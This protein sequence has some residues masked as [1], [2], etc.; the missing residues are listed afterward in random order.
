MSQSLDQFSDYYL[1]EN[2]TTDWGKGL[3]FDGPESAEVRR[4]VLANAAYW[5]EEF[6]FDGLR[7]DATQDIHDTSE[8]HILAALARQVRTSAGGRGTLVVAENEPQ[9]T[10]L[11][12]PASRGGFGIDALWN[13]DFHHS[14][15]VVL[16][17]RGEA[18]Y[19]D[20]RG[21]PQ[22]FISAAKYGYLYQGQWYKWQRR[23]GSPGLDL[24]PAAFINYIQN[25]DQVANSIRGE[26][27]HE[28]EQSGLLSGHDSPACCSCRERQCCFRAGVRLVAA[29]LL[30]ADRARKKGCRHATTG[31][32]SSQFPGYGP[33]A[34]ADHLLDPA[35]P[36]TFQRCKLDFAE[37]TSHAG[38][39]AMHR[40]LLRIRR[41]HRV[42]SRQRR[43]GVDE[44]SS[45]PRH[46]CCVFSARM[47]GELLIDR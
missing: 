6:H 43:G 17:G 10:R 40:D 4:F 18:Y 28:L 33:S 21:G 7:L 41:E 23:R 12:R 32:N 1:S 26:R 30:F 3:N 38:V 20:Y 42:F 37:R 8:E 34:G 31:E 46:L 14:A 36:D 47:E 24:P 44:R 5:I 39:Y 45:V 22:E 13:D 29:V 35:N 19:T 25:H 16:S 9:D 15:Q 27:C 11:V 2:H